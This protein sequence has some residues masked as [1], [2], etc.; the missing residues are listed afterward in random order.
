MSFQF[1]KS[2]GGFVV[3]ISKCGPEGVTMAWGEKIPPN[4]VTAQHLSPRD[5]FRLGCEGPSTGNWY[6]YDRGNTLDSVVQEVV[7]QLDIAEKWWAV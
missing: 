1:D 6:R 5:R 7:Q 4:K 3:E 2:G